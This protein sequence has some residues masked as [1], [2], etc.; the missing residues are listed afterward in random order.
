[1]R[2]PA[3]IGGAG[4]IIP[5]GRIDTCCIA[6]LLCV[7]F[8]SRPRPAAFPGAK[9]MYASVLRTDS[10]QIARDGQIFLNRANYGSMS[11]EAVRTHVRDW[12]L[13]E[14]VIDPEVIVHANP[15]E[16]LYLGKVVSDQGDE[17]HAFNVAFEL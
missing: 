3:P 17:L 7:A 2:P 14:G 13:S 5:T 9:P 4:D 12:A 1:M 11:A 16:P 6:S 15:D 10:A 8:N